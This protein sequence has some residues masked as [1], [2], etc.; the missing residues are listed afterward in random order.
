[1]TGIGEHHARLN[2]PDSESQGLNAFSHVDVGQERKN[3][4]DSHENMSEINKVE[5]KDR[6][7]QGMGGLRKYWAMKPNKLCCVHI[8][9]CE[10]NIAYIHITN[11]LINNFVQC[12]E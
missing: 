3:V 4:G 10:I 12:T 8:W 11:F 2:K 1:M 7:E 5:K 6:E 9:I